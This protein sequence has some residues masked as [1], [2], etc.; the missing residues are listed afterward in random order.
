M[1]L[2][3]AGEPII[4]YL[5]NVRKDGPIFRQSF[6]ALFDSVLAIKDDPLHFM[7]RFGDAVPRAHPLLSKRCAA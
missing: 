5:D 6:D 3:Q 2:S 4:L 1:P 7:G